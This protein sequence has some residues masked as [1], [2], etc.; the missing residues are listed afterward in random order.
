MQKLIPKREE[1]R[2]YIQR[3]CGNIHRT[4]SNDKHKDKNWKQNLTTLRENIIDKYQYNGNKPKYMVTRTYY[5]YE[6]DRRNIIKH[7]DR[8]NRV[9]DDLFNPR[10]IYEYFVSKDHFIER[11]KPT[12]ANK[13]EDE[14]RTIDEGDVHENEDWYIKEGGFHIHLL[15][16]EIDARVLQKPNSSIRRTW[17][18]ITGSPYIDPKLITTEEGQIGIIKKLLERT[19]QERCYFVSRGEPCIDITDAND[20]Y[21]YDDYQ[22]WKGLE[23]YTTKKM[24]NTD[25]ML[26]VFDND[27]STLTIKR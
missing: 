8:V 15:L 9:I 19:F 21:S 3:R 13:C 11:H 16:P 25:M 22:G 12:L 27:N 1:Y 20:K 14:G 2:Q 18:Q 6:S 7:N 17:K 26:E 24:Y 5:Y 4:E 23:A 10:G